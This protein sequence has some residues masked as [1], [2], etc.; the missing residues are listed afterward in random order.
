MDKGVDIIVSFWHTKLPSECDCDSKL[1]G[2]K[3]INNHLNCTI[4][5]FWW[6]QGE[7]N[8]F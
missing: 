3:K 6:L 2:L 4:S 8:V 5:F 7:S 1:A